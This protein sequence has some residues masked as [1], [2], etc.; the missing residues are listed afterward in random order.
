MDQHTA[1]T[2]HV[3]VGHQLRQTTAEACVCENLLNDIIHPGGCYSALGSCLHN[4]ISL[5]RER[6]LLILFSGENKLAVYLVFHFDGRYNRTSP[7]IRTPFKIVV[8]PLS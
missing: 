5:E 8:E 4:Q 3:C 1:N 7:K 2:L 6:T